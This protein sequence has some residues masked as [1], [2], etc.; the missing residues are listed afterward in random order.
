[1]NNGTC[2]TIDSVNIN[3]QTF[4]L[5]IGNDT[6]LCG[7]NSFFLDAGNPGGSYLWSTSDTTQT[8]TVTTSGD[9]WVTVNNSVC[10]GTDSIALSFNSAP[11]I[12]LSPDTMICVGSSITLD[13]GNVGATYLWSTS[14]T[15]QII[16]IDTPGLYWVSVTLNNCSGVSSVAVRPPPVLDLG[17]D[18]SLCYKAE[19]TL[20]SDIAANSFLWSTG[21]VNPS[22]IVTEPG[23]YWVI[24]QV[25]NCNLTDSIKVSGGEISLYIPNAFTPDNDGLNE[26]FTPIGEG[27]SNYHLMI[28]TRWGEMIFESNNINDGWDGKFKGNLC[29]VD[30]YAWVL[31]YGTICSGDRDLR[32]YGFVLL[33]K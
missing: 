4:N 7:L 1:V 5:D 19:V 10:S 15:S 25:E 33:M 8:I 32:R 3:F 12:A 28:F 31:E 23:E 17:R 26:V 22:I 24:A 6:V 21:N 9:Y 2:I 14:S 29:Q 11:I 30:I 16:T 18:V 27:I 20:S 13:A